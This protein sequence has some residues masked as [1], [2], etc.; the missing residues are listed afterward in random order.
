MEW[1]WSGVGVEF[2][3]SFSGLHG[4]GVEIKDTTSYVF[5]YNIDLENKT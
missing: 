4:N 3:W 5:D 1:S 2:Q